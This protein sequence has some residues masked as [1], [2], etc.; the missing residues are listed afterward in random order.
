MGLFRVLSLHVYWS[1][2][3]VAGISPAPV[4]IILISKLDPLTLLSYRIVAIV[5]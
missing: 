5:I 3:S 4:D 1:G 2:R